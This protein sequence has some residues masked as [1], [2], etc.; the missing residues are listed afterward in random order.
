L[1]H[2]NLLNIDDLDL[3]S[4]L[5]ILKEIVSLENDKPINIL[6]YI[7]RINYFSNKYIAHRIILTVTVIFEKSFTK[8]KS[9]KSYLKSIMSQNILN[10]LVLLSIKKYILNKINYNNLIDNFISQKILKINF[11]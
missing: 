1:K 9:I 11:K 4:K 6:P 5:N 2:D 7:K 8:F 3:F 10:R